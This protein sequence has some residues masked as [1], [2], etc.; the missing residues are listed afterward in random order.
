MTRRITFALLATGVAALALSACNDTAIDTHPDKPV[1]KRI[2]VFKQ[3]TRTL[4]P[5]GLVARER[6]DY[7]KREFLASALELEKLSNQPW[8]LFSADSNYPPTHAKAQ[9]W[10][11]SAEFKTAQDQ[12]QSLVSQLVKAAQ[13]A[14]LDVIRPAVNAVQKSC[15]ACHN[16]FRNDN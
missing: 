15:K 14:D 4:E 6:Q 5:M 7:N 16:Q 12:Y 1:T 10:S 3:F 11:Q 8:A 9:V 2:A 13:G